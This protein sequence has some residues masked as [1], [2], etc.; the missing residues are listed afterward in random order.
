MPPND[1]KKVRVQYTREALKEAMAAISEG[2]SVIKASAK[3]K[4]PCTTLHNKRRSKDI[5]RKPG[6]EKVLST[7]QEQSLVQW[8]IDC[9]NIGIPIVKQNLLNSVRLLI[10]SSDKA[11][12]FVTGKRW[13]KNFAQRHEDVVQ[14]ILTNTSIIRAAA[15]ESGVKNWFANVERYLGEKNILHIPPSR[16]FSSE[17]VYLANQGSRESDEDLCI[18]MTG[19]AAGQLVCPMIAFLQREVSSQVCEMMPPGWAIGKSESGCV[20]A[21][22]FYGYIKDYFHPWLV[23]NNIKLPVVL[24]LN[25]RVSHLTITL[26]NFCK[27]HKI[28]LIA[29]LPN[30]SSFLHPLETLFSPL[31]AAWHK[32]VKNHCKTIKTSTL[33]KAS[34]LVCVKFA[35]DTLNSAELLKIGFAKC[36]LHPL[37]ISFINIKA[38]PEKPEKVQKEQVESGPFVVAETF[39]P[40]EKKPKNSDEL[41]LQ[42]FEQKLDPTTLH[43]FRNAKKS[44]MWTGRVEDTALFYYWKNLVKQAL[45][46]CNIDGDSNT[47]Y[48]TLPDNQVIFDA[49]DLD[50]V[51]S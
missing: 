37:S 12:P 20:T 31:R 14:R 44:E 9:S 27:D 41:F 51:K 28:E 48:P 17:T 25:G 42:I 22:N 6:P 15:T 30:S 39:E 26:T 47:L 4:I 5:D 32:T 49:V 29:L 1:K 16:V 50:N 46:S 19:N 21:E 3:Y 13:Y 8:V 38:I 33:P 34:V 18:Q 35:L 2:M 45:N 43:T 24:F 36:G 11:S 23:K 40:A 10:Q 7:E